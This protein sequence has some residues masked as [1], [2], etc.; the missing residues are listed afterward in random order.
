MYYIS[1]SKIHGK[2][3]FAAK[4]I[5][6]DTIVASEP[7]I[8]INNPLIFSNDPISKYWW[9][10]AKFGIYFNKLLV[11]GLGCYCNNSETNINLKVKCNNKTNLFDFI[12]I[13]DINKDEELLIY[14]GK[15]YKWK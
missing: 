15:N 9:S 11:N 5:E 12:A 3:S 7:Y 4:F 8:I 2:G 6:K 14:Y 13:K 1:D 10:G